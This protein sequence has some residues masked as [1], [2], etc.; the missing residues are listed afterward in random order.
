MSSA[1]HVLV[2]NAGTLHVFH[3]ARELRRHG[4][5]K[6]CAT[7]LYFRD[8]TVQWLPALVRNRVLRSTA[9][10][11]CAAL[12]GVVATMPSGEIVCLVAGRLG[13]G[14]PKWLE[15]RNRRFCRWAARRCLDGVRLV[16]AFDTS[17]FELFVEAKRRGIRCVLDMSIAHPALGNR[18]TEEYARGRPELARCLESAVPANAMHRRRA[19]I[20]LADQVIV[21]S[22][23]VRDS[24]LEQGVPAE[25]IS[26]IPYGVD[27]DRFHPP[28]ADGSPRSAGVRFLFVGWFSAR[29]GVYDLLDAWAHSGLVRTGAELWLAGG[30]KSD[31]TCHGGDMPAG[32]SILG[33]LPHSALHDVYRSADVF[34]FPS[35]FEGSARVILEALASGLPV[36][37]TPTAC[38]Q[39][40]VVDGHNGFVVPIGE[41]RLVAD[42]MQRLVD[43]GDLRRK[44]AIR[45]RIVASRYTWSE[46]GDRCAAV[47]RAVLGEDRN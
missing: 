7:S 15:W 38:D 29:K 46:Y 21:G 42:R 28:A 20:D 18:I 4:L 23:V 2:A 35:L 30:E 12:D 13:L 11:R 47:C 40:W 25:K 37:T 31:L 17:S 6:R 26:V 34:V 27:V 45:A 16:W 43:D 8:D 3:A 14:G 44:M 22:S 9:N 36:I 19:E 39:H 32:A 24:L 33:R 5:L 10:R 1:E 41:P